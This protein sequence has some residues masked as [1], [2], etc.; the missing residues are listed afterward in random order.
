MR[1]SK[2]PREVAGTPGAPNGGAEVYASR[3]CRESR[4]LAYATIAA[5]A[6]MMATATRFDAREGV[7]DVSYPTGARGLS[8][9]GKL[10]ELGNA[11]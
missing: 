11:K 8:F 7:I 9:Q 4:Q 2:S 10:P 6:A 5:T 3:S 1:L